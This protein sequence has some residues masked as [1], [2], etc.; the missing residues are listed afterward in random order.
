LTF[1]KGKFLVYARANL[2]Y[3]IRWVQVT[4]STDMNTWSKFKLLK[5]SD[6]DPHR[7]SM[8]F[9]VVSPWGNT[10]LAFFPAVVNVSPKTVDKVSEYRNQN[11]GIFRS[12]SSDGYSWTTPLNVYETDKHNGRIAYHPVGIFRDA[13]VV[14]SPSS[15]NVH[16]GRPASVSFHISQNISGAV[17]SRHFKLKLTA[18]WRG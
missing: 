14:Q 18:L 7:I 8:Y 17:N 2:D 11:A 15:N 9:I 13:L 5:M 1:W 10:L 16:V 3:G 4:E 12:W 6:V